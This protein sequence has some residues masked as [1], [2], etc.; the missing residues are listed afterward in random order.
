MEENKP[1]RKQ[2]RLPEFLYR[3]GCFFVTINVRDHKRVFGE[4]VWEEMKLN[5]YGEMVK[6][7][8]WWLAKQYD[9][10]ILGESVVMPN[11]FHGLIYIESVGDVRERPL[12]QK[13]KSLGSLIATFKTVSSKKIHQSWLTSFKWQRSFYDHIIRN[14][15]DLQE[16]QNYI[17]LNPYKRENG[18]YYKK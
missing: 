7:C 15:Q 18:E 4:V 16:H 11:H 2:N 10:V 14:D 9:Y 13:H 8:R 5:K 12:R 6:E 17:E 1:S 3:E